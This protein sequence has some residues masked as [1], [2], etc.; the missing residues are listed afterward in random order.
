M[1][2]HFGLKDEYWTFVQ[3]CYLLFVTYEKQTHWLAVPYMLLCTCTKMAA[4]SRIV[5]EQCRIQCKLFP[6]FQG[7]PY[8]YERVC[9]GTF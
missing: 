6:F 1:S 5:A 7:Y 2:V 9:N 4:T 3:Y 8:A